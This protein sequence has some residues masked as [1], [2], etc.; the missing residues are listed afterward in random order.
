LKKTPK[1]AK[2]TGISTPKVTLKRPGAFEG[3]LSAQRSAESAQAPSAWS[4]ALGA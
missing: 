2:K 3:E 4:R 1:K